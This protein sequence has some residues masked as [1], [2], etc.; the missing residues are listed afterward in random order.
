MVRMSL[1]VLAA[2]PGSSA[3][4][5]SLR[6]L[7]AMPRRMTDAYGRTIR[8]LRL[9]ITDRCNFRCVYCMDPGMRF[10]PAAD[11]LSVDEL[12]RVA[13]VCIGL[14]VEGV[15]L[16]GGEPTLHPGLE[17]IVAGA[18]RLGVRALSMTTNGTHCTHDNLSRWRD[19]GLRRITYSMDA[20]DPAV[21][22]EMT[23]SNT[24]SSAV[25]EAVQTAIN[26]GLAPVKVNAVVIRGRNEHQIAPLARLARS[27]GFEMRFIEY[28]PLDSGRH[29]DP[30]LLVPADEILDRAAEAVDLER[31][32]RERESSTAEVFEILGAPP[33]RGARL[34][35]I[36]PVTRPFCG[37]CSRLR[38]TADGQVRP[39][40][41]SMQE[42]DLR[43][44]LRSGET[45]RQ[46]EERLI[47]AV[48]RKQAGHGIGRDGFRQPGRGMSAI[49]G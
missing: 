44:P 10:L 22:A 18:A 29:W 33:D 13:R 25:I 30:S 48:R 34:G 16:T 45:D 1:S 46:L 19:L 38:I 41:F 40:L 36:A 20:A 7:P 31:T 43:T 23:R 11:L 4:E 21:F 26:V 9:S 35:V 8:D 3:P 6:T 49:G 5:E 28:M 32:G 15:R 39:C 27:I 37:A 42:Y 17:E 12:V 2:R 14:G 47:A 24:A